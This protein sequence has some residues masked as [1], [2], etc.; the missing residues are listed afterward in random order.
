MKI[1][2]LIAA[3]HAGNF[4]GKA[5]ESIHRQRCEDWELVV[6]EDGSQDGTEALVKDFATTVSQP[7]RYESLG[8]HRGVATA[9]NRLM[10]LAE[11]EVFAFLDADDWWSPVHLEVTQALFE[12]GADVVVARTQ[13][14]DLDADHPLSIFTPPD[15]LF[16]NPVRAL[17]DK[18]CIM[19]SSSVALSQQAARRIGW[20]DPAFQ[21]GEDRDYWLRCALGGCHFRDSGNVTCTYAKH[22]A[23]T[24]SKTL[25][26]AEQETAFYEKYVS[27]GGVPA[28]LR[29]DRLAVCLL[30]LGRLLRARNPAASTVALWRAWKLA[31]WRLRLI[32]H[33]L[34]SAGSIALKNNPAP[35]GV[36][37]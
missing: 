31:P 36:E 11:G 30:N 26:W 21:I 34:F 5:L 10:E 4:L 33:L 15:Q 27:L 20:F 37:S 6:V 13:I 25:L 1:S 18:S 8:T 22:G 19:T 28:E 29:R 9:R 23:S 32:S 3:Y 24:M 35:T 2:I 16:K 7:V 12:K 14:Y 17:F